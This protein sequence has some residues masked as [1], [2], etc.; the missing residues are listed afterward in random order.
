MG[1]VLCYALMTSSV[2]CS[3]LLQWQFMLCRDCIGSL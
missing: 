3:V 2:C 1:I